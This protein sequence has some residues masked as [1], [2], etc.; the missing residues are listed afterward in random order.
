[1][2]NLPITRSLA[3]LSEFFVSQYLKNKHSICICFKIILPQ[4]VHVGIFYTIL[5]KNN[6]TFIPNNSL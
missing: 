4:I 1:M 2:T 3:T 5:H 6:I